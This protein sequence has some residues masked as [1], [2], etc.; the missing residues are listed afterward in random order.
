MA[1]IIPTI[2]GSNLDQVI[3]GT[4]QSEIIFAFGGNDVVYAGDGNDSIDGSWGNDFLGGQNGD[5][6]L[7]GGVGNDTLDGG[8]GSDTYIVTGNSAIGMQGYETYKD[9]GIGGTDRILAQGVGNVDIG[10]FNFSPAS[11]IEI[12]DGTGATGQ[13]RMLGDW[14]ANL[15]DFSAVQFVGNNIVIDGDGQDDTIVGTQGNDTIIGGAGNDTLNGGNGSDTYLI[16]GNEAL[17]WPIYQG[18]DDYRDNGTTG[19]DRIVA[20]GSGDVDIGVLGFSAASGIEVID[21]T[22]AA[23]IVRVRSQNLANLLDFSTVQFIG[24]N[25]WI[26]GSRGIDTII[27]TSG[28]DTIIGGGDADYMDGGQGSDTYRITGNL[29]TNDW[30]SFEDH[31]TYYD[32]GTVGVDRIVAIG[33]GNVDIGL[34]NFS[35][36]MSG[37]EVIDGTGAAGVVRLVGNWLN[38]YFDFSNTQ[39]IGNNFEIHGD[40]MRDDGGF[41]TIIGSQG[42]DKIFGGGG[43]DTMD[44]GNGSDT[45]FIDGNY[46]CGWNIFSGYDTYRD[47]GTSGVDRI[48]VVPLDKLQT[49]LLLSYANIY[50]P[51]V[52]VNCVDIGI[53]NFSNSGIEMI[54]GTRVTGTV[55]LLGNWD[56]NMMDFSQ[57][58]FLGSNFVIKGDGGNDTIMG[59]QG[60]DSMIGGIGSDVLSGGNGNDT[61]VGGRE[62]DVLNGGNGS[63]TYFVSGVFG[64]SD[65]G[66]IDTY[67]DTGTSGTDIIVATGVGNVDIGMLNFS[68]ANGIEKIDGTGATGK[69]Q[70]LGNWQANVLDFSSIQLVGSNLVINGDGQAD[71]LI[72]SIGNDT[73]DGGQGGDYLTGG[74]GADTLSGGEAWNTFIF[75]SIADIGKGL[76]TRDVITDFKPNQDVIRLNAIDANSL[77]AGDQ[78]FVFIGSANF[79]GQAGQLRFAAGVLSG[80]V[81]ADL[82]A[83]FELAFTNGATLTAYDLRL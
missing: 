80:D 69:V 25:I 14:Q 27:G 60:D 54:D 31:D 38:N 82:V 29:D 75:N 11:G 20:I 15:L 72:G 70:I 79:S 26:D 58:Q 62:S 30:L 50:T 2:Y 46:A 10:V 47:T 5:D 65:W 59:S 71:T 56:P 57:V 16:T 40:G 9:T 7:V 48:V 44:G 74:L 83:D 53:Q 67:N 24:S 61:L 37:I 34:V 42:D 39:L 52:D 41:D 6:T 64:G 78:A 68:A 32:T 19:T 28:N 18:L 4:L 13:V 8:E 43:Y 1:T 33:S 3:T 66:G 35:T 36:A 77:V 23:G 55:T 51:V 73:I 21:G 17:G 49:E 22:G 63:D 45:Y 76:G 81:N 12:V